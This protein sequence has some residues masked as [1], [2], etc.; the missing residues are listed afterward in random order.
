MSKRKK[1]KKRKQSKPSPSVLDHQVGM[2]VQF[3][4]VQSQVLAP[5][6]FQ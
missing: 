6:V 3:T 5:H 4:N 1:G 2:A